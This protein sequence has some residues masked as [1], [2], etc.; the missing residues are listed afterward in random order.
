MK[1]SVLVSST[2]MTTVFAVAGTANAQPVAGPAAPAA[3]ETTPEKPAAMPPGMETM[4]VST[5]SPSMG[6]MMEPTAAPRAVAGEPVTTLHNLEP[7]EGWP[8]PT[9][10]D[11]PYS[12]V[13]LD[14]LE[15][16]ENTGVGSLRWDGFGWFGGDYNRIWVKSEGTQS[17]GSG[18]GGEA[19]AQLLY[20]RLISPYFDLQAGA[21]VASRWGNGS[22]LTRGYAVLGL[23]GLSPYRF[24]IESALFLSTKG[25]ISGRLTASYDQLLTQ[26]LILQPRI[27]TSFA[28]QKDEAFGV[29]S[30]LNDVE[31]GLRARYE[32]RR[33][34]APYIGITHRRSFGST[35]RIL[36]AEGEQTRQT[37]IVA[38]VRVWF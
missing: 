22:N 25:Q 26:R 3:Q 12:L 11:A 33:E 37:S 8:S 10:D 5:P 27:D 17:L 30:G 6:T 4:P 18:G 20:G 15:Y 2:I 23:Q 31:L 21:R 34:F 38:G 28:L 24:E 35:R 36:Q 14:L 1:W 19:E 29:G 13:L 16:R 7:Q 9:A 32:I